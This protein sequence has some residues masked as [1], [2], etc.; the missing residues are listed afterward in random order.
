M[1][2]PLFIKCPT[3]EGADLITFDMDEVIAFHD[4]GGTYD[5]QDTCHVFVRGVSNPF[6]VATTSDKIRDLAKR[7]RDKRKVAKQ[8][9]PDSSDIYPR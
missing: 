4:I 2:E 1:T 5:T 8:G 3:A 6:H 7:L 9:S